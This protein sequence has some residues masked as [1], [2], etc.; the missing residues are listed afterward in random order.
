[1]VLRFRLYHAGAL[2]TKSSHGVEYIA[3]LSV[4]CFFE[5]DVD[6]R[7]GACAAHARAAVQD[8]RTCEAAFMTTF[9]EADQ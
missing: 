8:H 9:L 7:E 4:Q 3:A 1:M 6:G 5:R 2:L